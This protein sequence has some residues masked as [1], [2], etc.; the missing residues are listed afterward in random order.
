MKKK[1]NPLVSAE[2]SRRGKKG[3][4]EMKKRI[5]ERAKELQKSGEMKTGN[6]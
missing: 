1:I 6:A 5:I 4:E 2:M 3:A